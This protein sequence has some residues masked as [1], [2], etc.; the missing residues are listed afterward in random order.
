MFLR[1]INIKYF[2]G[3]ILL[4]ISL[5]TTSQTFP[6]QRFSV[7]Q[8]LTHSNV[9]RV[10]QD[11]RGYLWFSTAYGLSKF[12]GRNFKNFTTEDGLNSNTIMSVMQMPENKLWINSFGGVNIFQNDSIISWSNKE[13]FNSIQCFSSVIYDNKIWLI[14]MGNGQQL[15]QIKD[16]KIK[17]ISLKDN[18]GKEILFYKIYK[19]PSVGLLFCTNIGVYS[20]TSKNGFSKIFSD[21]LNERIYDIIKDKYNNYW[22]SLENRII[23]LRDGK[24]IYSYLLP[25]K[26]FGS[27]LL[28][29]NHN[30]IFVAIPQL[31]M[32][33][34]KDH[35]V[36]DITE[37]LGIGNV[38]INDLFL[39]KENNIWIAS[40]GNGVYRLNSIDV[41]NYRV[42]KSKL[43]VYANSI[44]NDNDNMLV[45]TYGTISKISNKVI[46]V[47]PSSKINSIDCIYFLK[48]I[49]PDKLM[50]GLPY[51][52]IIKSL[53]EPLKE[54]LIS[55]AGAI[56]I[57]LDHNKKIWLGSFGQLYSLENNK[58]IEES[59]F[60]ILD[61]K[62][63]NSII[64]DH[65]YNLWVG[66]NAGVFVIN[67]KRNECL[68]QELPNNSVWSINQIFE[69]RKYNLWLATDNG[70]L[71]KN[72]LAWKW[73]KKTDGLIDN[74]CNA[75]CEINNDN[76]LVGTLLGLNRVNITDFK[77][78]ELRIG[79][80]PTEILS[81]AEDKNKQLYIGT[82]NGVSIVNYNVSVVKNVPPPI[83]INTVMI[84]STKYFY[85]SNIVAPYKTNKLKI[86]YTALNFS[87]PEG[88]E[89]RWRLEPGSKNWNI[90]TNKSIEMP[91]LSQGEYE[92][93][94]EAR[95]NKGEWGKASKL[96]ISI[97]TPFWKT[98]WFISLELLILILSIY[99][100]LSYRFK[101]KTEKEK[102]EQLVIN[103]I[104]YFKEQAFH[105]LIN[106]H[107][108]FNC[109]N[110]IQYYIR[111]NNNEL[112]YKYLDQFG[113]LIRMILDHS[114]ETFIELKSE[115]ERL[116]IYLSLEKLR[117][118]NLLS[119]TI[120]IDSAL[121][122]YKI[123][124]PN[125]I[126]QPYV[127]NAI[128]HGIMPKSVPGNVDIYIDKTDDEFFKISI[129]DDGVGIKE[130]KL[131][132]DMSINR[133]C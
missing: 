45:G 110:S 90:T 74:K 114:Q 15:V 51:G 89:Y 70:L 61:G 128:W 43:S 52:V 76:I 14:R 131:V 85:P 133:V 64:E 91:T 84:D 58:I 57:C 3:V 99:I 25:N 26:L 19:D 129:I 65:N 104:N 93:V 8:G 73:L 35:L 97:P 68:K 2:L 83:Y 95:V 11:N 31:G 79:V 67:E 12:D 102:Q 94:V 80:L 30:N 44:I 82:V 27:N 118:G 22:V 105:A 87:Y 127:E 123:T 109:M 103:K 49:T 1:R 42:D 34:I 66:T 24:I 132:K 28:A 86:E 122:I 78:M 72:K 69:D 77:I 32:L 121:D 13:E 62:R 96:I 116:E 38:I 16:H 54:E 60:K 100:I 92:F 124:I 50:I 88:I 37:K 101:K 5:K 59:V 125:M 71:V 56:S 46:T 41:L 130:K 55:G 29:D 106:P 75:I 36:E 126:I 33:L 10:F 9:F 7:T 112:A 4:L 117:C 63:I 81:M 48:K 98:W 53:K 40:H 47:L 6:I 20:Y 17:I 111:K 115:L 18:S 107:F 39:D 120:K 119:Y 108:I 21:I 113:I 23:E